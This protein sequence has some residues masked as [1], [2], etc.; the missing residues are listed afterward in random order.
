MVFVACVSLMA[1][2]LACETISTWEVQRLALTGEAVW[3]AAG[4]SR[5]VDMKKLDAQLREH[6]LSS[7][8]AMYY[9]NA[10]Q[11][12]PPGTE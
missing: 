11:V 4:V 9:R 3:G 10:D 5:K 8:E 1:L 7:H 12:L 6:R 2:V